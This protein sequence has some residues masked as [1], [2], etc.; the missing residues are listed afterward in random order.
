MGSSLPSFMS[1]K[2]WG[3]LE[4]LKFPWEIAWNPYLKDI[5]PRTHVRDIH[6]LAIDVMPVGIPAADSHSLFSKVG[7]CIAPLQSC[8]EGCS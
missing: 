5:V 3:C 8:R 7:T 6:P 4:K 1:G 2:M